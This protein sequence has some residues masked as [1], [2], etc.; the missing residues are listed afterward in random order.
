MASSLESPSGPRIPWLRIGAEGVAI[1]VSILLA[2]G[3]QAWWELRGEVAEEREILVGLEAEFEALRSRLDP[4]A[5]RNRAGERLATMALTESPSEVMGRAEADTLFA[6]ATIVNVL[7][8][9]GGPLDALLASGRLELIRDREIRT[10][11]ARWPDRMEDIHTNDLSFRD[12]VRQ[13]IGPFLSARGIPDAACKNFQLYTC[14]ETGPLPDSYVEVLE[15]PQFRAMLTSRRF[16]MTV[17]A[18]DHE[19]ARDEAD[20]LLGMI[21]RQLAL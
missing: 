3:I 12:A 6:L 14:G 13:G 16:M 19:A 5:R 10:R 15:D 8:R 18:V 7:D 9:G 20:E 2:F 11:L 21:R 17:A 4:L 1:V